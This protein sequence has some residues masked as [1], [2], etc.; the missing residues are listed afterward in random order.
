[1]W[2]FVTDANVKLYLISRIF[3]PVTHIDVSLEI[4]VWLAVLCSAICLM[5]DVLNKI[6]TLNTGPNLLLAPLQ[7][8]LSVAEP[9]H[10][11]SHGA[12]MK[13][14]AMNVLMEARKGG[15]E[16]ENDQIGMEMR[17]REIK[18]KAGGWL[19]LCIFLYMLF[20]QSW[21]HFITVIF[22]IQ[23]AQNPS[24][25]AATVDRWEPFRWLLWIS[26]M[27]PRDLVGNQWAQ[28]LYG[29]LSRSNCWAVCKS[30]HKDRMPQ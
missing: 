25:P 17:G 7:S 29:I 14:S 30:R 11:W 22:V 6:P 9:E 28:R 24:I 5:I 18:R 15:G 12:P 2:L 26:Y 13:H 3:H 20:F 19:D 8:W 21:G 16:G 4:N 10:R 23:K 27:L 1:M